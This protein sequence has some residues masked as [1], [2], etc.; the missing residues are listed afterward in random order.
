MRNK[1]KSPLLCLPDTNSLIH[2][3][4]IYVVNK[5]LWEWLWEEFDVR[6]SE[7]M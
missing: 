2:M 7:T 3:H 6:L 5:K 1:P 4:D